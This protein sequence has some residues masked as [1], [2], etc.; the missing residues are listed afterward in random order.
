MN[1]CT[2]F[3]SLIYV[4]LSKSQA[5]I[6]ERAGGGHGP[7]ASEELHFL[8]ASDF[9]LDIFMVYFFFLILEQYVLLGNVG[10]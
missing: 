9:V 5:R 1:S 3:I 8:G 10:P 2:H 6:I 7:R 4:Y